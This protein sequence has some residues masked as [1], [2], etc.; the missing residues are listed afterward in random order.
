MSCPFPSSQLTYCW[1]CTCSTRLISVP[2]PDVEPISDRMEATFAGPIGSAYE[3]GMLRC[4]S[5]FLQII[6]S[7]AG[8]NRVGLGIDDWKIDVENTQILKQRCTWICAPHFQMVWTHGASMKCM[9]KT[10]LY[11]SYDHSWGSRTSSP[12]PKVLLFE[13]RREWPLRQRFG[14]PVCT[15][16]MVAWS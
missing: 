4:S 6:P 8:P 14:Y 1:L 2:D 9:M 15:L 12:C 10:V 3:G 11:D 16:Q 7:G 13:G 5:K